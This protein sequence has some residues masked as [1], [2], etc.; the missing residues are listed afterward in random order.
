[1]A[2]SDFYTYR[3]V[4]LAGNTIRD[5]LEG[6]TGDIVEGNVAAPIRWTGSLLLEAPPWWDMWRTRIQVVYHRTG[7]PE[8][9]VGTFHARPET[10][11][12][13]A[14]RVQVTVALYDLTVHVQEDETSQVWT[15]TAGSVVTSRVQSIL[16]GIGLTTSITP[17][18]ETLRRDLVFEETATKLRVINDML[19]AAGFFALHVNNLGQFQVRPYLPPQQRPVV[20]TFAPRP[21]AEHTA[22]VETEFPQTL[23]N[24][25][26]GKA[27][28][29]GDA[30]DLVSVATDAADFAQTGVWR[31]KTYDGLEA[32]SQAILDMQT[33][34][35]L[36]TARDTS[37]TVER[38]MLPGPLAINDVVADDTGARYVVEK[39]TRR[40]QPGQ[41]MT[42]RMR[43]VK[44]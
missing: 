1:M 4:D 5:R 35:L 34:R 19:D 44:E 26:I 2:F 38:D 22:R 39:I 37:T 30:P 3:L 10:S 25:V 31:S 27:P 41:T 24:K 20:Y 42:V 43:E 13:A 9:I 21:D 33:A 12:A 40:L 7:R 14:G 28:G 15:E 23:P 17:S 11:V 6:V 32:T 29:D 8:E 18:A 36:E 16:A